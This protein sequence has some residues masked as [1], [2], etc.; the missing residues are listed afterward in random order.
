MAPTYLVTFISMT[1]SEAP[2]STEPEPVGAPAPRAGLRAAARRLLS[3]PPADGSAEGDQEAAGAGG[4]AEAGELPAPDAQV[5]RLLRQSAAWSWRL[6]LTGLLIYITFRLAVDLR[7]VVL[8]FIA[9]LLLTALLQ[10]LTGRLR[11]AGLAPLL[12]TWCTFLLAIIV[13]AGAVTLFADRVSADYTTLADEVT[14]TAREVQ[15]SLAGAPFH[16]NAHR[17]QSYTNELV[18]YLSQHK[19]Q[20]A[21]TVLA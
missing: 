18:N 10:P 20:I 5:P 6:L 17:L 12:A 11:R 21:G 8:P 3:R 16:L 1:G 9:A 2:P 7:L 15:R 14:R 13:I 19:A 4:H